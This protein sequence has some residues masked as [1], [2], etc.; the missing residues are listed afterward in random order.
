MNLSVGG[1]V[2]GATSGATGGGEGI[3]SHPPIPPI[4]PTQPMQPMPRLE[5]EAAKLSWVHGA[6]NMV[7]FHSDDNKVRVR[8]LE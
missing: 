6:N 4:H 8:L 3:Y 7:L 1:G 2:G 5:E